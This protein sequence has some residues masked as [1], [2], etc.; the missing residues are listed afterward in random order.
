MKTQR[1]VF[2]IGVVGL[3]GVAGSVQAGLFVD[4][5]N[6]PDTSNGHAD[7]LGNG[8]IDGTGEYGSREGQWT[9]YDGEC[10][11]KNT[12][13]D[14]SPADH[15]ILNKNAVTTIGGF[16]LDFDFRIGSSPKLSANGGLFEVGDRDGKKGDDG[17]MVS[18]S[19]DRFLFERIENGNRITLKEATYLDDLT[20][21]AKTEYH[22]SLGSV[23]ADTWLFELSGPKGQ[24]LASQKLERSD[25]KSWENTENL[26][27]GIMHGPENDEGTLTYFD[28]FKVDSA[29]AVPEPAMISLILVF[30]G[31]LMATHRLLKRAKS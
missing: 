25:S 2:A 4:D 27:G 14:W 13:R 15:Y 9:I 28:N 30:G 22:F 23:D 12:D 18:L 31:G 8:W 21:E 11:G 10:V 6:R 20:L 26:L 3:L 5:F 19:G 16:S 29:G 7:V 24:K 1:R 17:Y